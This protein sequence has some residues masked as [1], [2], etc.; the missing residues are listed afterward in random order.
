MTVQAQEAARNKARESATHPKVAELRQVIANPSTP[1]TERRAATLELAA[2]RPERIALQKK[3]G[4][5]VAAAQAE[6]SKARK[7][8]QLEADREQAAKLESLPTEQL[9]ARRHAIAA[10]QRKLKAEKRAVVRVLNARDRV[11]RLGD[12]IDT[13]GDED[14]AELVQ[15]IGAKGVKS[16]EQVPAPGARTKP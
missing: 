6:L 5:A 14:Q 1:A 3:N 15:M 7:Q 16:Q 2:L 10:E 9:V 11:K 13:L 4:A 12:L 8:A